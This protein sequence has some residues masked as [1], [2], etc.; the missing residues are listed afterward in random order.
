M[1]RALASDR[2]NPHIDEITVQHLVDHATP[3]S[4]F[5]A[6]E[7]TVKELQRQVGQHSKAQDRGVTFAN[8]QTPKQKGAG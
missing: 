8:K 7:A 2:P 1:V 5:L 3:M 4:S 6:L